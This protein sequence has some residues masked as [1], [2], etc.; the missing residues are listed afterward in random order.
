[1]NGYA[2]VFPVLYVTVLLILGATE[3]VI[4]ASISNGVLRTIV[5]VVVGA[6]F[7]FIAF[8]LMMISHIQTAP[9]A[10]PRLHGTMQFV[11]SIWIN[12][13]SHHVC[14]AVR[15]PKVWPRMF[16]KTAT[17]EQVSPEGGVVGSLYDLRLRQWWKTIVIRWEIVD[18]RPGSMIAFK[19][20]MDDDNRPPWIQG[21]AFQFTY[22]L[23]LEG[24]RTKVTQ[25]VKMPAYED[26]R[27]N[28]M[29]K[30]TWCGYRFGHLI[31]QSHLQRL[32][33]IVEGS[34]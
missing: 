19:G 4:F 15:S 5:A 6:A 33:G 2:K 28:W 3:G 7:G 11:D 30:F 1:M 26:F 27:F 9:Y 20:T 25:R 31:G 13:P 21:W 34:A 10:A 22:E 12:A 17:C 29:V 8:R 32:K 14:E 23:K 18:L 24:F 16:A